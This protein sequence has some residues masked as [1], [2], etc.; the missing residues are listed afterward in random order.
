M[1]VHGVLPKPDMFLSLRR[2]ERPYATVGYIMMFAMHFAVYAW[3]LWIA[4]A[5]V[6]FLRQRQK[7][8]AEAKEQ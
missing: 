3:F 2:Y 8:Q 1:C 7:S 4:R 5:K 6:A